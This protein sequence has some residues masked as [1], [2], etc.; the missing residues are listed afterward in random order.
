MSRSYGFHVCSLNAPLVTM[1]RGLRPGLAVLLDRL[2]R[3]RT[4]EL[5]R[6]QAGEKRHRLRQA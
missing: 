3:H 4:E 5:M 2:A 6:D 1:C